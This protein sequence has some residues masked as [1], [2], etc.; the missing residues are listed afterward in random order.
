ME[1]LEG[2]GFEVEVS[3]R[4]FV[5]PERGGTQG[6]GRAGSRGAS[7]GDG[8]HRDQVPAAGRGNRPHNPA[9]AAPDRERAEI[10]SGYFRD[11]EVGAI[12]D[13]SGGSIAN[14]V[15]G[16]LDWDAI[17]GNP[18][19]FVGYS[20]LSTLVNSIHTVTGEPT[21]L[22]QILALGSRESAWE[23]AKE[24]YGDARERFEA[25]VLRG[26]PGIFE[27]DDVRFLQGS[28]MV[29]ELV[30]GNLSCLLKL[31]G[32]DWFPALEGRILALE[33]LSS[34]AATVHTYLTQLKHLGAFDWCEGILLG[35]FTRLSRIYGHGA[36]ER[37]VED[38]VDTDIPIARTESFGHSADSRALKVGGA[39]EFSG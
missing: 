9:H 23:D 3:P 11:P 15:L 5:P 34:D 31:A 14:G 13:V 10:L 27:L 36:L 1:Y 26:E 21:Y 7:S 2:L 32:T 28:S 16:Y 17:R 8:P 29:G 19:P 30:G 39:Y 12:F 38:V 24:D 4:L 35:Q 6:E 25:T 18:K 20:D 22:W 33:A 37:I